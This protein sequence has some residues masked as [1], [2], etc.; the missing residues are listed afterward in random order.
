M[1]IRGLTR[2]RLVGLVEASYLVVHLVASYLVDLL[3]ASYLVGIGPVAS[4]L[5]GISPVVPSMGIPDLVVLLGSLEVVL[6]VGI[7]QA[8][9]ILVDYSR[10][11]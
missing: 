9:H 10:R 5:V 2:N 6:Q 3:V 1:Y 11:W 7:I 4:Y 8:F